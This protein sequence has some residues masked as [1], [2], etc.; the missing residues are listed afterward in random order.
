M[1]LPR[2]V[3]CWRPDDTTPANK[4]SDLLSR[5]LTIERGSSIVTSLLSAENKITQLKEKLQQLFIVGET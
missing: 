4:R 5:L 2:G 1:N 3:S